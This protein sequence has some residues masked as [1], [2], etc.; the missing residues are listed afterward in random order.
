MRRS[1]R[2]EEKGEGELGDANEGVGEGE[3][4][5]EMMRDNDLQWEQQQQQQ[6]YTTPQS[7]QQQQQQRSAEGRVQV[8]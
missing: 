4:R 1:H 5:Q 3:C 7:E 2:S 8:G 6:Q